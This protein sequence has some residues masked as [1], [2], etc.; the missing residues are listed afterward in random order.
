MQ[1]LPQLH[2]H[3]CSSDLDP[4]TRVR[5]VLPF[6]N[7]IVHP[8]IFNLVPK[9]KYVILDVCNLPRRETDAVTAREKVCAYCQ[10]NQVD[11]E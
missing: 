1:I 5:A 4:S 7:P 8:F 9:A 10:Q 2:H 6:G 3:K 11:N